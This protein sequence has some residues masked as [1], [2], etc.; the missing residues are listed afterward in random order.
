MAGSKIYMAGQN[1]MRSAG[2]VF[3]CPV[4]LDCLHFFTKGPAEQRIRNLVGDKGIDADLIGAPSLGANHFECGGG[5]SIHVEM[6]D[7]Q[8]NR[9][10]IP[11]SHFGA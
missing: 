1:V 4:D 5:D 9:T 7:A 2:R 10:E 8:G 11:L 3:D 6:I